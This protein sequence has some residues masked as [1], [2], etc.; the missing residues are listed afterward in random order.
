MWSEK[1]LQHD[2]VRLY[3]MA[4]SLHILVHCSVLE[5]KKPNIDLAMIFAHLAN[6][7]NKTNY[8]ATN[9]RGF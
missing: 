8:H 7:G 9:R 5:I 4:H 1:L 3:R 6:F 2:Y